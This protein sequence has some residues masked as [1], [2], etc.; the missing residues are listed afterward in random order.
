MATSRICPWKITD[1]IIFNPPF[2]TR[3]ARFCA[4]L[5]GQRVRP[6]DT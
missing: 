4:L 6:V 2:Q 5:A 1:L 3:V